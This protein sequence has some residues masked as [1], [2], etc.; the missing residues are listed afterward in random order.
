MNSNAIACITPFSHLNSLTKMWH[1]Q[2]TFQ[3]LSF[4]FLE[5]VKLVELAMVQIIDIVENERY[6]FTLAL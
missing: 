6:F 2:I 5:Y 1:L 3:V 4:S